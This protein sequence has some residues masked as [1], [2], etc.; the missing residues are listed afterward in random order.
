MKDLQILAN[1]CMDEL[2]ALD[3]PYNK[4]IKFEINSRAKCRWGQCRKTYDYY[5]ISISDRLLNDSVD[6]VATKTT[7]LHE[8]LHTTPNGMTHKGEWKIYADAVNHYYGYNIKRCT[9]ADE[10]GVESIRVERKHHITYVCQCDKCG[11]IIEKHK[12]S[13]FI[14]FPNHYGHK[15]CNG[16][17]KLID[18]KEN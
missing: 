6:D 10:K 11:L 14:R 15:N 12:M 13:N 5:I 18:I 16:R 9:S 1:E 4:N 7:I 3:I 2:N 17:F 8:L